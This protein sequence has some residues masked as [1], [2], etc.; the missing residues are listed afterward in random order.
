MV[1]GEGVYCEWGGYSELYW[2]GGGGVLWVKWGL[3][4]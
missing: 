3:L 1:G 2:W 4:T